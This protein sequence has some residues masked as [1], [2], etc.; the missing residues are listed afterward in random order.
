MPETVKKNNRLKLFPMQ[1]YVFF[2]VH[3]VQPRRHALSA[4][5]NMSSKD[6][7]HQ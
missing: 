7:K 6:K 2:P 3:A 1:M 4:P 5:K